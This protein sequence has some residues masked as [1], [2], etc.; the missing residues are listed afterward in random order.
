MRIK[1]LSSRLAL[2]A[3][4]LAAPLA[5]Q[6]TAAS[7]SAPAAPATP[8]KL[9][10]VISVD[11]F[12]TDVFEEYRR[13][14][15]G[16]LKRLQEGVVFPNG[17]QGHAATETCPGHSTIL[18]GSRPAR[19]GVIANSWID[20]SVARAEKTV[21]CSEDPD[22]PG[23]TPR[24]YVASN[25]YLRVPTLGGRMKAAN[26]AAKVISVAG[27]DRAAIMMGGKTLDQIWWWGNGGFTSYR[28]TT[29]TPLVERVNAG[30]RTL[31]DQERPALDLPETCR[32]RDYPVQI[33]EDFVV[34][35]GRFA[36]K[37]GDER[38][39]R[40]SPEFDAAVLVLA[41][42]LIEDQKLGR[43]AAT[44]LISI[45]LSAT[46]YVGH[47]Y[48]TEGTE[49]CLQAFAL[50]REL[51]AFLDRLDASGV[52]YMVTLTAD[53]GG[54]DA[55]ERMRMNGIPDAQRLDRAFRT[56]EIARQVAQETGLAGTLLLGDLDIYLG[57][58]LSPADKARVLA[59][60]LR[61]IRAHP[62]VAAAF[63]RAE[64]MAAPAP[65][66]PPESWSLLT[67]AKASFDPERSGDISVLTRPRVNQAAV[68]RPGYASGHGTP[69]DHD[70]RVPMLFWRKGM[71]HYEQPHGVE[72]ADILPTLAAQI[73]LSIDMSQIDGRCLDLVAGPADSCPAK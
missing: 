24:D 12:S 46:D 73:G 30:V 1:R 14:F 72:T 52:D 59:A 67:K 53:H 51:G 56:P 36:R 70:R 2:G 3:M 49:M 38:A 37:A 29:L 39:F 13:H 21:Y 69:W 47:G 45:G 54:M 60:A 58:S 62:Q 8:P 35:T 19:T 44:D 6:P 68:P 10:V 41:T 7:S 25:R 43:G 42:S 18:T 20:Q 32:A 63:T 61:I 22:A 71:S 28:G 48:G 57:A 31:I 4:L 26:A 9:L 66:G 65:S 27:K 23:A 11:Q 34:G 15:T 50:D 17:Y 64:I 33:T 5:A 40:T 16:G 55:P